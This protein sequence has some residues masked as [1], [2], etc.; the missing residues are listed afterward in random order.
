MT[1]YIDSN[2]YKQEKNCYLTLGDNDPLPKVRE[3][4]LNIIIEI[5]NIKTDAYNRVGLYYI[6]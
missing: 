4:Y 1:L 5:L 6:F 2:Y 3:G